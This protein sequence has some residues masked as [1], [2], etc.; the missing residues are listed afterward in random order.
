[1]VEQ[2]EHVEH[3]NQAQALVSQ[4]ADNSTTLLDIELPLSPDFDWLG[5][6][7]TSLYWFI[8]V[9]IFAG[10]VSLYLM[11]KTRHQP[12]AKQSVLLH[13]IMVRKQFKKLRHSIDLTA[14][15]KPIS[16]TT[17]MKFYALMQR[18]E[19]V[20]GVLQSHSAN[21]ISPITQLNDL[22][23][24][25]DLM[26]F[27]KQTVSRENVILAIEATHKQINTQLTSKH[28]VRYYLQ[29]LN[30]QKIKPTHKRGHE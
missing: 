11:F 7:T 23:E 29:K 15:E 10:L 5:L 19:Y 28:L 21:T 6:V 17:I 1:M 12:F 24:Q 3:V 20:F 14:N 2:V 8:V 27:S 18:L 4:T 30:G 26:A 25:A 9:L 22:K 13:F 16:K